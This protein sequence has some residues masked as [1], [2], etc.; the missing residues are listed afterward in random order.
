MEE[1]TSKPAS[2]ESI[3]AKLGRLSYRYRALV[4][5]VWGGLLLLSLIS[6][7]RLDNALTGIGTVYQEGEA[8]RAEQVLK[9]EL[10]SDPDDVL[11]LVLESLG[12]QPIAQRQSEFERLLNQVRSVPSVGSVASATEG[13]NYGSTDDSVSYRS[14]N[15]KESSSEQK[16]QAVERIQEAIAQSDTPD[17]NAYLIGQPVI[18]VEAQRI[19]KADLRRAEAITLPLTLIALLFVFGSVLAAGMPLVMGIVTVSVTFGLMWLVA[20]GMDLSVFALNITTM[21]GLGI[22]ID[23]SL[24]IVNR[25]RE[26]LPCGSVE[27]AVVR[28]VDTAGRTV[29]FSGFTTCIGLVSLLLF[30]IVLLQS[31]GVGGFLVVLLSVAAALTLLP[32]LLGVLRGGVNRWRVLRIAPQQSGIWRAIAR[33]IIR[34][35]VAATL[36]VIAIIALLVYPFSQARFGLGDADVLPRDVPAR[37]GIEVLK[38]SF[39]AGAVSPLLLVVSTNNPNDSILSEQHLTTLNNLVS[40]LQDNPR[41]AQIQSIVNLNPNLSLQDYQQL[42]RNPQSLPPNLANALKQLSSNSTTLIRVYSRTTRELVGEI[43]SF[44]LEDL[45]LQVGGQPASQLDTIQVISQRFWWVL[46]AIVVVTFVVLFVHFN[47]L[48]IP[49]KAIFLNLMSIGASFGALVFVFQQ[50]NFHTWLNFTPLGYLHI[51]LPVILFCVLFGLS[52]DY[53]VFLLTRIKEAYDHSGNNTRSLIEGL[54][55]TGRIITS[56]AVLMIIVT[57]GFGLT[58]IIFV[59]ALGLGV[60]LAVFIDATLIRV[61]L[62]PASMHLLGKWNWWSPKFLRPDRTK[63]KPD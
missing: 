30:P 17:L 29:F 18:N 12:N 63:F 33:R 34:H 38:Q 32:A 9:Q 58:Q 43:R 27:Q 51:L 44:S 35:S 54:E 59:K 14:I 42:Y 46:T 5:A 16:K 23:S 37:Q 4:I 53:E 10:N 31:L 48:I 20:H 36:L 45:S 24:L 62:V 6:I 13:L 28:T 1:S 25:F 21:L 3:F 26:E 22:G 61:I 7:P 47:S 11:T 50:G 55:R 56:A 57:G 8:A 40:N 52:M 60:A 19:S 2:R 15:L 39:G 49:L 41:V